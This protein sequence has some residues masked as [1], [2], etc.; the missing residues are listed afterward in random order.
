MSI[1]VRYPPSPTGY[2]HIGGVRSALF[3]YFFAKANK[4]RFILRIEDTDR[5]RYTKDALDDIYKTFDW[6]GIHWDEGPD[7]GGDYGPYLQS[8]RL[9]LY[10]KYAQQL[11]D[12]GQAYYCY[13]TP[14][15]LEQV[16]KI[17]NGYDYHC[18]DLKEEEKKRLEAQS[19][20]RVI[21][22]KIPPEGKTGFNDELLG[23]IE[24]ANKDIN[25]DPVILKS[26]GFPTYHLAN[27]IDDHLMKITHIMR[28]Q[29][30]LSSGPLHVLLYKAFG[31]QVPKYCHLPLVLGKDGHKLSKRHGATR[32]IEFKDKGYLPEAMINYIALLGWSFD[33]KREFFSR[34]ELESLFSMKRIN[35]SPAVFDYKKLDWFNGQ[36][37]RKLSQKELGQRLLPFLIRDG[38]VGKQPTAAEEQIMEKMIPLVQE[39]L[40]SLSDVSNMIRFLF[41]G[42]ATFKKADLIPKRLDKQKTLVVLMD[43]RNLLMD[44][45]NKTDQE[46]EE[47]FRKLAQE[48]E[49]KLGDLLMPLRIAL[50]GSK[51]SPPLFGS[52]RL[53]GR[54]ETLKRVDKAIDLLT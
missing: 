16:R 27:V 39:R 6:L 3:N 11:I 53:I 20:T 7:V 26:D 28:A 22:F 5:E 1:R 45:F 33:D 4:G 29:E 25:P 17:Y 31:W 8:E 15:R 12:T 30:W 34:Q 46:N 10:Q 54:E 18:R 19:K 49:I 51:V 44:F 41:K 24:R 23:Y 21:R 38:L 52:I 37:I 43:S 47:A 42:I 13:C 32:V 50:T 14:E 48:L 9:P 35:K 36:Y 2:Q 40:H